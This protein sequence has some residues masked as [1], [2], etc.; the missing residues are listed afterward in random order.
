MQAKANKIKRLKK[1][2][3]KKKKRIQFLVWNR[4]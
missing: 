3:K 1:L 4:S 2:I